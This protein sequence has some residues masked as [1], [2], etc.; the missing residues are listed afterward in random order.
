V[1]TANDLGFFHLP[2][3][4]FYAECLAR[5]D[6]FLWW[7]QQYTGVYLHGEGQGGFLHPLQWLGYRLLPLPAAFELELLRAPAFA[8]AGLALFLR[9]RR[10]PAAASLLGALVFAFSSFSLLHFIH[11]NL[12]G[13]WSHVP[14]CLLAIE[15]YLG[16]AQ[17]A[18]RALAGGALV[19]LTASQL[20][21]GH[22]QGVWLALLVEAP[23][24]LW[25][26]RG[27][28]RPAELW[29]LAAAALLG[30]GVAAVQVLPTLDALARSARAR[31]S[32]AFAATPALAPADLAQLVAPYLFES[33]VAGGISWERAAWPGA[34]PLALAAW[35]WLRRRA[36]GSGRGLAGF[37][38]ALTLLG[39]WLALGDAGGLYRALRALPGLDALRAPA[40][41]VA[42][43]QLG[44]ALAAAVAFADLARVAQPLAWRR[45][46]PLAVPPLAGAALLAAALALAPA[47]GL[48]LAASPARLA[49]GP[50]L[51]AAACALVAAAARGRAPALPA[52]VALAALDLGAYGLWAAAREPRETLA[53][54]AA[55]QPA[56]P[57][58]LEARVLAGPP[59]LALRGLRLAQGYLALP[60]A[61][62]LA[63]ARGE[64]GERETA[65]WRNALRVAEVGFAFG[66]ALDPP[67]PRARL[68]TRARVAAD[69]NEALADIDVA[70]EALVAAPLALEAGAPGRARI[71]R[72]RPGE[73]RVETAAPGR[74]LLVLSE[75]YHPG[76]RASAGG[77]PCEVLPVYGDFL[78]CV[79]E[80][81][82]REVVFRFEPPSFFAARWLSAASLAATALGALA[83]AR[84]RPA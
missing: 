33:R 25:A 3:R 36:L 73:I 71:A 22:P 50:L 72:E 12:V 17:P 53:A 56:T 79:V 6:P 77:A 24:A 32:A 9:A 60:P 65:R 54:F 7:P 1:H 26:A 64:D 59:A 34:V 40:R 20:L 69:A 41:H 4:A 43:A 55:R 19:L 30:C 63:L 38:A 58:G 70:G 10:L 82:E 39:L 81:G 80:A 48:E 15:R 42:L 27:R 8:F 28:A 57:P 16:A 49:A 5:G 62:A 46:W 68:V 84:R 66:A 51:L 76:W 37:A 75:S 14:W 45:L 21:L 67:L 44:L 61:R 83:L 47:L 29:P 31:E 52:L 23:Y 78:G 74:Q 2:V 35:L 18:A 13:V 11:P